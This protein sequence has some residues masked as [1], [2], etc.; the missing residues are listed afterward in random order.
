M[1][2]T[3]Y[4]QA[5]EYLEFFIRPMVF[6]KIT[7]ENGQE[8]DP[9]DR[10]R[11]L[12]ELLGNP[13]EAFRSVVVSGSAGKGSTAY[14]LSHILTDA[15]YKTGLSISPHLQK[16]TERMQVNGKLLPDG[17]FVVLINEIVPVIEKMRTLPIGEPSYFEILLALAF[18]HFA[19]EKVDIAVI[20]VGLE[21]KYDGTNVLSP[22][23][24]VL[25]NVNLDHIDILGDTVEKIAD[26]AV[27]FI[28]RKDQVVITGV[29]QP[30]VLDIV[31]KRCQESTTGY[32]L[33]DKD[34]RYEIRT[35]RVDGTVFDFMR[36]EEAFR[37][38]HITL[39]GAY[40]AEN[41]AL[42]IEAALQ[43]KQFG[44][45]VSEVHVREALT[46]AVFPGRFEVCNYTLNANNNTLILDGAHNPAKM[47]AFLTSLK[48]LYPE[49]KKVFL[50]T[51]K[52]G[53]QVDEMVRMIVEQADA[54]V[55][56]EFHRT[57][58]DQ[59]NA[60]LHSEYVEQAVRPLIKEKKIPLYSEDSSEHA[61]TTAFKT[62]ERMENGLVVVTGSLYLV[63]EIKELLEH[64]TLLSAG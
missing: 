16:I 36:G 56:T 26:E 25:T 32:L 13:Q 20:E 3:T 47:V 34:F 61:L 27:S 55:V 43:L 41:A 9:L 21:G 8:V 48:K 57:I 60:S 42:A 58:D 22:L 63:G 45:E 4:D 37:D 1:Q 39:V 50:I 18:L 30:S 6:R 46:T 5:R 44:Y 52:K 15:G 11:K 24:S 49:H 54:V 33:L 28:K 35:E 7:L 62:A 31:R 10:M 64:E 29:K 23:V 2:I 59:K 51:F 40:Q 12:L 53:K 19:K 17:Q 38:L 14:L